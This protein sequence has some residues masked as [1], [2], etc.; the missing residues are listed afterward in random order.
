MKREV[1]LDNSATTK[2]L[3][4]V[5]DEV[6]KVLMEDYGNP[7]SL[8]SKGLYAEKAV[9]EARRVISNFLGVEEKEIYFTSGGTESNN[10]AIKG[11][12]KALKR[13]GKHIITTS[14]EHP[15]VLEV[16]RELEEEGFKVTY[17]PV[18]ED[19]IVKVSDVKNAVNSETVLVSIMHVNNEVGSIQPIEEIADFL[20]EK[21]IVFHVDAVQ[22]FGKIPLISGL[23][24]IS[25]LSASAHKV[26]GPKG[27]GILYKKDK[28]KIEPLIHGG[29]QERGLR[30]GTENVPGIAGFCKAVE[31][32]EKNFSLWKEKMGNL[33]ERLK[34]GII[35]LI[36]DVVINTPETK[37]APHILNVSFLGV[38]A[39]VLL[40]ALENYGIY[41][42]TGSA[43]SSH[44]KVKSH[45]LVAMGKKEE[46][47][48][49]AVR[50][51]LSPFITEEEI[52][53]TLDVL[54]NQVKELRRFKRR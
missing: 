31:I 2:V 35:D 23:K 13:K 7:S 12:V 28:I 25:L 46:E 16:C 47:I 5:A 48:E 21:G 3:K 15:S 27:I 11:A 34:T 26:Y 39:E 44:K 37:S 49:G 30:S 38:K 45:V 40:H 29:G 10:V 52:D 42:S 22:S 50:F 20:K 32:L 1:Y 18:G 33:K 43:C 51:S 53:Y 8:H 54:K 17:L 9:R 4:E 19:G 41:V 6:Y 14:I 24:G 36:E